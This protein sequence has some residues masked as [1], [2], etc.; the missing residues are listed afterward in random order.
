[1]PVETE[2]NDKQNIKANLNKKK[3]L[4]MD[5]RKREMNMLINVRGKMNMKN[6]TDANIYTKLNMNINIAMDMHENMNPNTKI[7]VDMKVKMQTTMNVK[8]NMNIKI[9]VNEI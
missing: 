5:G 2:E 6:G 8:T 4:K 1:M 9:N 7:T 3:T